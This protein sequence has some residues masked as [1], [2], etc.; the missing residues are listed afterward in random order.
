MIRR[1]IFAVALVAAL[2][3]GF[4]QTTITIQPTTGTGPDALVRGSESASVNQTVKLILP[5]AT[6]LHLDATTI[7]FDLTKPT[8]GT[9]EGKLPHACIYALGDDVASV[10]GGNFWN[11]TQVLPGGTKYDLAADGTLS[12]TGTEAL[13][14]PPA[15]LD[16]DGELVPGSK[17][18]FVC[19]Q[20]FIIQ[21][22]CGRLT[23]SLT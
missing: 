17:D 14:Y 3:V 19:Y 2:G 5:Q 9:V 21:L 8:L 4:A 12:I 23:N 15:Q 13:N 1:L 10:Q 11:Q 16:G 22:W 7:A 20:S 6:A 18:H